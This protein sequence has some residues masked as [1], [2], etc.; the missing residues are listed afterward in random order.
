MSEKEIIL[1]QLFEIDIALLKAKEVI[2]TQKRIGYM[3]PKLAMHF[4]QLFTNLYGLMENRT[5]LI[6]IA[7]SKYGLNIK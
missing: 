3:T 5:K 2:E 7:N 6:E 4:Q 1:M